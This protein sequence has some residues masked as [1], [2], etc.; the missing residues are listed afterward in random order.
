MVV[1]VLGGM[2]ERRRWITLEQME[3]VR[4]AMTEAEYEK[5]LSA[6]V[7]P[8][9]E[10]RWGYENSASRLQRSDRAECHAKVIWDRIG[11]R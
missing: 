8:G 5:C 7:R 2:R 11:R 6:A 10:R 9:A 3:Q 1:A 4:G